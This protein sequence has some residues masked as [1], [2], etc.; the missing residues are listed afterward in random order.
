ALNLAAGSEDNPYIKMSANGYRLPTE[1]EWEYAA[2][3]QQNGTFM[4]GDAPSGWQDSIVNSTVDNVEIDAVVWWSNNA[5]GATH[6]VGTSV[7]NALGLY[8]MNGNV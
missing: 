6:A 7:P 3:Y 5:L 1:A 8:D 2:R 4:R